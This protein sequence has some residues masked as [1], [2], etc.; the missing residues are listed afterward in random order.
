[1]PSGVVAY[2]LNDD[3][4]KMPFKFIWIYISDTKLIKFMIEI[5]FQMNC[6]VI[7]RDIG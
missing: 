4:M 2:H 6:K 3:C 5:S 7:I 1:M